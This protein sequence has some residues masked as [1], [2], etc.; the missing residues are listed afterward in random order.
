MITSPRRSG[1][2]SVVSLPSPFE[3]VECPSEFHTV[4]SAL[5]SQGGATRAP[6]A[7][8]SRFAAD[9]CAAFRTAVDQVI[10]PLS[11]RVLAS[12]PGTDGGGGRI[13]LVQRHASP[14][15]LT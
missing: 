10:L 7:L 3:T 5:I 12:H 8:L 15:V 1:P 13:A 9:G 11:T 4:D 2:S 6:A 14:G